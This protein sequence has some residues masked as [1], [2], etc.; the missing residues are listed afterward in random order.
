M[1]QDMVVLES[2]GMR[3]Q[4]IE[5][6]LEASNYRGFPV[7]SNK[8]NMQLLGYIGR[9][10]LTYLLDKAR[11]LNKANN[12]TMCRFKPD[13]DETENL[14]DISSSDPVIQA[15]LKYWILELTLIKRLLLFIPN[16]I[17]RLSWICSSSLDHV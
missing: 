9:T 12:Q 11:S 6:L 15:R 2:K 17:W 14:S 16:S 4:D 3:I 7:V 5:E 13:E 10:E 1:Q 8:S